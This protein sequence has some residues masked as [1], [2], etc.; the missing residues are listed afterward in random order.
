MSEKPDL[1]H[2]RQ[3]IGRST[4]ASDTVTAQLPT[5]QWA[6]F[7]CHGQSDLND[8]SASHLLLTDQPLT[9]N[10][11]THTHLP[12]AGLAFLSACTTARS[13]T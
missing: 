3:W 11:L 12:G 1:D 5:H 8:P 2:L 6:H 10:E 13:Q 7:S 4:E 9:V